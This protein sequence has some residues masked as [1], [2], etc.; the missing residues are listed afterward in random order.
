VLEALAS[1]T[2]VVTADRGGARE[3]VDEASGAWGFPDP[4]SLADAVLE[5]VSRPVSRRRAAARE[6]AARYPWTATV[7]SMLE[8]HSSAGMPAPATVTCR[9]S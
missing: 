6:R 9:S 5:V 3:L 4:G 7:A 8:V 2:P 1:G